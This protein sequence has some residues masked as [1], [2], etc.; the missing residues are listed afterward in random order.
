M[1]GRKGREE[2]G[3]MKHYSLEDFQADG[4]KMDSLY[5]LVNIAARRVN[6]ISKPDARPLAHA[7]SKKPVMI[8]LEEVLEGKISYTTGDGEED[9][10]EVG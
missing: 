3:Y 9:D 8:A 1:Y 6:Q 5:R 7:Q 4:G 10:F 2:A